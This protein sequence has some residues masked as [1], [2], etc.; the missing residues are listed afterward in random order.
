MKKFLRDWLICCSLLVGATDALAASPTNDNDANTQN[1]ALNILV[2]GDSLSAAYGIQTEDGWVNLLQ[3]QLKR[4]APDSQVHNASISGET[5]DGGLR[6]LPALLERLQP[7]IVIIGLGA[8]DA[9]RG[10]PLS[11]TEHNLRTMAK[12]AQQASAQVLLLGMHIPP[13]YGA[14]YAQ[15]FH[16]L[17]EKI[18]QE[19]TL[20][21]VPFLLEGVA[22]KEN[23]MQN[24]RLHPNTQAQP[25]ILRNVWPHLQPLLA[26]L[27]PEIPW[28]A[29]LTNSNAA[30]SE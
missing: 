28:P 15:A 17:Y 23:L 21:K 9:L 1:Q 2:L 11:T 26:T 13:N 3:R 8:N 4:W 30:L 20:A 22:T 7:K 10:F 18:A 27:A 12:L 5:T 24:D 29:A 14:R 25:L 19:Q 16:D 6:T